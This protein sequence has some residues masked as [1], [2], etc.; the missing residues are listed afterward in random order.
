MGARGAIGLSGRALMTACLLNKQHSSD[1]LSDIAPVCACEGAESAG[2]ERAFLRRYEIVSR[3]I[4]QPRRDP[5]NLEQLLSA[6]AL[7][8]VRTKAKY[9][10]RSKVQTE[11][12]V[13]AA[14]MVHQGAV[15]SA[16][17]QRRLEQARTLVEG[18]A[19]VRYSENVMDLHAS[20]RCAKSAHHPLPEGPGDGL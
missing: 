9:S 13:V 7:C 4:F 20:L 3:T 14:S 15:P 12:H 11:L 18:K 1:C 10:A 19:P 17:R 16:S 8:A 6:T 5:S 2:P